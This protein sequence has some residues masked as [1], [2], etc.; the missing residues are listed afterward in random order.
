MLGN[1]MDFSSCAIRIGFHKSSHIWSKGTINDN[2]IGS[3]GPS[4]YDKIN[5]F[6]DHLAMYRQK[7]S[8]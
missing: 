7:W 3:P 5:G 2:I 8:G 6:P 4:M 1:Q